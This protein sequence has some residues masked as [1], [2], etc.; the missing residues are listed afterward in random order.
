MCSRSETVSPPSFAEV[1]Q[2]LAEFRWNIILKLSRW[3]TDVHPALH[4]DGP[5]GHID[6]V[7]RIEECDIIIGIFW[8]RFRQ[9]YKG[10][11]SNTEHEIHRAYEWW[12]Q[13]HRPAVM[14]FFNQHPYTPKTSLETD[15]WGK[16]L[17]F[18][19]K[20]AALGVYRDYT[21]EVDFA[22]RARSALLSYITNMDRRLLLQ[23]N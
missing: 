10:A 18:K 8:K 7:L 2:T 21:G 16:V 15:E 13:I 23:Q 14:Q 19:A 20:F 3:K 11:G 12:K 22:N 6:T 9:P 1:N 4:T 5:Q 17:D